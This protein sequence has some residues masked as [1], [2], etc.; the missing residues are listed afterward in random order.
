MSIYN[1][2]AQSP[3]WDRCLFVVT[4]DEHGGFFDH[5]APPVIAHEPNPGFEQLGFRV[6]TIVA[7]PRVQRG[8]T[9]STQFDH[10]SIISTLTRRF[11]LE[12]LNERVVATADLSLCLDP[13]SK[14]ARPAEQ[15]DPVE[16]SLGALAARPDVG[17]EHVEIA[18]AAVPAFDRRRESRAITERVLRYGEAL[19]AVRL[20]D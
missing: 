10:V 14:R 18:A 5:V 19:G 4:Y 20:V 15:L 9:I 7:G 11:G 6:P 3:Q 2:L 12:P 1:A 17:G 8:V 13:T 16:I